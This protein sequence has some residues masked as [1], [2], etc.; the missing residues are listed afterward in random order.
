MEGEIKNLQRK[1][2]DKDNKD[3]NEHYDRL[4]FNEGSLWMSILI[5]INYSRQMF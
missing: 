1:L 3:Q 5:C 4:K 2:G